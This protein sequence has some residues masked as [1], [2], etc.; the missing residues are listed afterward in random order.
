[1]C[2]LSGALFYAAFVRLVSIFYKSSR[3]NV[4]TLTGVLSVPIFLAAGAAF[5]YTKAVQLESHLQDIADSAA[6]AAAGELGLASADE[7]S[8][9]ETVFCLCSKP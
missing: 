6:L 1:M 3:A 2:G 9:K 5:D 8:I 4:T 7:Q